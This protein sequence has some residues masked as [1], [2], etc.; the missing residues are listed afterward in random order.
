MANSGDLATALLVSDDAG[1]RVAITGILEEAGYSVIHVERGEARA[2]ALE[3]PVDVILLDLSEPS[4]A[5]ETARQ[6][7]AACVAPFVP[8][9]R[10]ATAEEEARPL[11]ESVEVGSE[12]VLAKPV[13]LPVLLSMVSTLVRLGRAHR[14]AERERAELEEVL[15]Q[16]PSGVIVADATGEL[17]LANAQA[18]EILCLPPA[19]PSQEERMKLLHPCVHGALPGIETWP[20]WRALRTGER[21]IGEEVEVTCGDDRRVVV[22]VSA[23][24]VRSPEGRIIAGVLTFTDITAR[25]LTEEALREGEERLR[26][27]VDNSQDAIIVTDPAGEGRVLS[28]NPAASRM[29]GWA[30]EELVGMSREDLLETRDPRL[31]PALAER[32]RNDVMQAELHYKRKDGS[33]LAGEVA[34]RLFLDRDGNRRAV[35][36][37][38]D[39]SERTRMEEEKERL[40]AEVERERTFLTAFLDNSPTAMAYLDTDLRFVRVNRIYAEWAGMPAEELVGRSHFEIWGMRERIETM[41]QVLASG[42]PVRRSEMLLTYPVRLSR[43]DGYVDYAIFPVKDDR[44]R[45]IGLVLS[46]EDATERVRA[47]QEATAAA[48]ARAEQAQLLEAILDNV[49]S[50]IA[51]LDPDLRY[52]HVNPMYERIVGRSREELLG[53]AVLDFVVDERGAELV[54]QAR[55]TGEPLQREE[56]PYRFMGPPERTAYL[57]VALAPIRDEHGELSGL[58][59]AVVDV[60]GQVETRERMLAVE[61]ARAE[62]AESLNREIAHRTKNNLAMVAGLLRF[63]ILEHPDARVSVT[64]SDTVTRLMT[65]ASIQDELQAAATTGWLDLLP[66]LRRVASASSGTFAGAEAVVSV[67]GESVALPSRAATSIAVVANEFITNALKHG[68][69]G[70]DG[71]LRVDVEMEPTDGSLRLC[72]WNSGNPVPADFDL[73]AH[74][75]M[76]LQLVASLVADQ[77][78]GELSLRPERGGTLAQAIVPLADLQ[79]Q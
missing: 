29:L 78:G 18:R 7:R 19:S 58:V 5:E 22:R 45:T 48:R 43:P 32:A 33:T 53:H 35:G 79:R 54:R 62:L 23:G 64:L 6:L 68:A 51:Y 10:L 13:A 36:I 76:G 20:L 24:P 40:L 39:V 9:L 72:V 11:V 70:A 56:F 61:R 8:I 30:E 42:E 75:A 47:R 3:R 12:A 50:G 15:R 67:R 52:V 71:K 69:A 60:T 21:V 66:L 26:A 59:A 57:N 63:Q 1:A 46:V 17:H 38:R 41:H 28:V 14:K 55:E 34:S 65:F 2:C 44:G 31:E 4:I 49:H 16:M 27:I 77:Y 73:R 25:Q 74:Q 37:I